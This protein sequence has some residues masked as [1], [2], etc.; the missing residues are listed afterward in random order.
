M[1]TAGTTNPSNQVEDFG[2]LT[3]ATMT[4]K[5][6]ATEPRLDKSIQTITGIQHRNLRSQGPQEAIKPFSPGGLSPAETS[7]CVACLLRAT[8]YYETLATVS[9]PCG[10]GQ[11]GKETGRLPVLKTH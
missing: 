6:K 5:V 2:S 3:F 8:V 9:R 11:T 4:S 10:T 7:T 1:T